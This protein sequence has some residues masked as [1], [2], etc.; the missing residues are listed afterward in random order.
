MQWILFVV[1]DNRGFPKGD[2][3]GIGARIVLEQYKFTKKATSN[4]TWTLNPR[5]VVLT[6]CVQSHAFLPTELSGQMLI[7][8]SLTQLLCINW[9]LDFRGTERILLK[10][11]KHD[12]IRII[13]VSVFQ[14]VGISSWQEGCTQD[15]STT[16]LGSRVQV[17]LQVSFLVNLFCSNTILASMP[18]WS[19]LG[20]PRLWF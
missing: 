11:I 13:K 15:M 3:S 5:T 7:Q 19:T 16:V 10:S 20:K 2:H 14:A 9:L 18:E 8:G 1:I 4:R 12:Y 17:L 6:S